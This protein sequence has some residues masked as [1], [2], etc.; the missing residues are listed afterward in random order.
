MSHSDFKLSHSDLRILVWTAPSCLQ[1]RTSKS[2]A[3]CAPS[4]WVYDLVMFCAIIRRTHPTLLPCSM[5]RIPPQQSVCVIP[6]WRCRRNYLCLH[7]FFKCWSLFYLNVQRHIYLHT[8]LCVTEAFIIYLFHIWDVEKL[9]SCFH[10]GQRYWEGC[11]RSYKENIRR[12]IFC[13]GR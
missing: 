11:I 8:P 4:R 10:T 1:A 9:D 2:P 6:A 3:T 12:I 5:S 7:R 13:K